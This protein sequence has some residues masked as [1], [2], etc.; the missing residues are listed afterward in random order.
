MRLVQSQSKSQTIFFEDDEMKVA[1][2]LSLL[3][4]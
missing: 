3:D 4:A 2:E 1:Y